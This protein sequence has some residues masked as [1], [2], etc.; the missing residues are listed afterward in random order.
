MLDQY[1]R[2]ISLCVTRGWLSEPGRTLMDRKW[3]IAVLIVVVAWMT[4]GCGSSTWE[5]KNRPMPGHTISSPT[6]DIT[7]E[8]PTPGHTLVSPVVEAPASSPIPQRVPAS[9]T[10]SPA[11]K[12]RDHIAY[13]SIFTHDRPQIYRVDD[14]GTNP[15]QLTQDDDSRYRVPVWS[16]DGSRLAF[17]S[18]IH[19]DFHS[20]IYIMDADGTNVTQLTPP[21]MSVGDPA[22]SPDGR[23]IAFDSIPFD[24]NSDTGGAIYIMHTDGTDLIRLAGFSV[25]IPYAS[26]WSPDG[27]QIAFTVIHERGT[28]IYVM[29]TDGSHTAQLTNDASSFELEWSPDGWHIV[30]TSNRDGDYEIYVMDADGSNVIQLTHNDVD[31]FEPHWSPDGNHITFWSRLDELFRSDV[32]TINADGSDLI[33]LTDTGENKRPVW[34]PDGAR[35]AFMSGR[36]ERYSHWDY[37]IYVMD[38]DGTNVVQITRN[39]WDDLD[40]VWRPR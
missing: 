38:A 40:P 29:D 9:P 37:E 6:P 13:I 27:K 31:D 1:T 30:F 7:D 3:R 20:E 26:C 23:F 5:E 33:Q 35:I 17:L 19:C 4:T 24:T 16:P 32:Y 21:D 14:E 18:S 2:S 25:N 8:I 10:P 11:L 22:W 36:I 12:T 34:S 39:L 28:D 15:V